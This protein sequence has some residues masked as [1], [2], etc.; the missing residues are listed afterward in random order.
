MHVNALL[1]CEHTLLLQ[2]TL[3]SR[4]RQHYWRDRPCFAC[5]TLHTGMHTM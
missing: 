1:V 2:Q 4:S 3:E 5:G